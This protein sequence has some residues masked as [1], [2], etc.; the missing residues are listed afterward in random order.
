MGKSCFFSAAPAAAAAFVRVAAGV[1]SAA[2]TLSCLSCRS[3]QIPFE[4]QARSNNDAVLAYQEGQRLEAE[5]K[6]RAALD[7]YSQALS[8]VKIHDAALYKTGRM[9]ALCG[10][11]DRAVDSFEMLLQDDPGNS[12]VRQSL[13]YVFC[14]SGQEAEGL[15]L[16]RTLHE[17]K[18]H[19]E[20][21]FQG[22]IKALRQNGL[23]AEVQEAEAE[24]EAL[25]PQQAFQRPA[26]SVSKNPADF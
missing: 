11:W 4:R 14:Q 26:E 21:I 16:Y 17:E 9:A 10:D 12:S 24:F 8:Y 18:P 7:S 5:G 1:L 20:L 19:D 25:F 13:A 15:A 2:I 6:Y 3:G 22:Y 23:D